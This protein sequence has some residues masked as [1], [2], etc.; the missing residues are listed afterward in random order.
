MNDLLQILQVIAALNGQP[1]Q[2]QPINTHQPTAG[3]IYV[4]PN[5]RTCGWSEVRVDGGDRWIYR[6]VDGCYGTVIGERWEK[7][8]R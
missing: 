5:P 2:H 8:I 7:K 3:Y 6:R 1:T 4:D